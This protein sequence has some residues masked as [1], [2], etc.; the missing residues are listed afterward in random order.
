M[1]IGL[2]ET[3]LMQIILK[4]E[5]I[6]TSLLEVREKKKKKCRIHIFICKKLAGDWKNTVQ[7]AIFKF[8]II[9]KLIIA[10]L[11]MIGLRRNTILYK[12][13][14]IITYICTLWK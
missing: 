2:K 7:T 12:S 10:D 3:G 4:P 13:T 14:K 9:I 1:D 11:K 5:N 8:I 6:Q